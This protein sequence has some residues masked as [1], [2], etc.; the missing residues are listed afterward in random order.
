MRN[1]LNDL[2]I[3][4]K[5]VLGFGLVGAL[6]LGVIGRYQSGLAGVSQGYERLMNTSV[7]QSQEGLAKDIL[8]AV[9]QARRSEKDFLLRLDPSYEDKVVKQVTRVQELSKELI[10]RA[11]ETNNPD[12]VNYATTI[13][14]KIGNYSKAFSDVVNAWRRKGFTAEDGLQGKFR[15]VAHQLESQL[16]E[17]DV[18]DLRVLLLES[19]R[20]EKDLRLRRDAKYAVRHHELATAFGKE[21]EKSLLGKASREKI[22]ALFNKY[23]AVFIKVSKEIAEK[24]TDAEAETTKLLSETSHELERFL[25]T[26]Y[27]ENVW[28]NY[29]LARRAEK[30]YM[31]RKDDKYAKQ[32]QSFVGQLVQDIE[33]SSLDDANKSKLKK[34]LGDYHAAFLDV[35]VEDGRIKESEERMRNAVHAVD[36]PVVATLKPL[37]DNDV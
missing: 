9:L 12:G 28:R 1:F 37:C 6:F 7:T 33:S 30:D 25:N 3:K 15:S 18:D 27:V 17:F 4:W 32:V 14:E 24:G 19:R 8:V 29:L 34:L 10:H 31:A 2:S 35:V 23:E 20:A 11:Q 13:L 26:L 22:L 16:K 21:I 36:A 5:L